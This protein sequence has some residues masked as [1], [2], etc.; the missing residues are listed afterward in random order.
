MT[1][2]AYQ[3]NLPEKRINTS[4][5][6]FGGKTKEHL[7]LSSYSNSFELNP[8]FFLFIFFKSHYINALNKPLNSRTKIQLDDQNKW[9]TY[10]DKQLFFHA[11]IQISSV[12][13]CVHKKKMELNYRCSVDVR[14]FQFFCFR[15]AVTVTQCLYIVVGSY[16][17]VRFLCQSGSKQSRKKNLCYHW[18]MVTNVYNCE[19]IEWT[20]Q[21][22]DTQKKSSVDFHA[23]VLGFF[24]FRFYSLNRIGK[25]IWNHPHLNNKMNVKN[26]ATM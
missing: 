23:F 15:F 6:V 19:Q 22:R 7:L 26:E 11:R 14:L 8:I 1:N 3:I 20:E 24:F 18:T 17:W 16:E 25:T 12:C 21:K 2:K 10:T 5:A 4:I 9:R 13:V